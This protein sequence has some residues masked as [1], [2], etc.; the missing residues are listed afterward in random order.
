MLQHPLVRVHDGAIEGADDLRVLLR[1]LL[2]HQ[3]RVTGER[4]ERG[5]FAAAVVEQHDPGAALHQR[6]GGRRGSRRDVHLALLQRRHLRLARAGRD[7]RQV[8]LGVEPGPLRVHAD[9][10][11]GERAAPADGD[12]RPFERG[13]FCS[14]LLAAV[15][16]FWA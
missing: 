9:H 4:L 16:P 6:L 14:A 15:S 12:L 1:V 11:V 7:D 5:I 10:H 3:D 13:G 2:A 8:L